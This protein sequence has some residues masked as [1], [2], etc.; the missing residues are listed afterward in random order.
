[1]NLPLPRPR[2]FRRDTIAMGFVCLASPVL[3]AQITPPDLPA[4]VAPEGNLPSRA[5][6]IEGTNAG[7]LSSPVGN[8]KVATYFLP[9]LLESIKNRKIYAPANFDMVRWRDV[10]GFTA[11]KVKFESDIEKIGFFYGPSRVFGAP[12]F[13]SQPQ[14]QFSTF[15]RQSANSTVPSLT[16]HLELSLRRHPVSAHTFIAIFGPPTIISRNPFGSNPAHPIPTLPPTDTFGNLG[17]RWRFN[18]PKV[19]VVQFGFVAAANG[20]AE[21]FTLDVERTEPITRNLSR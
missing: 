4:I 20:N 18:E 8:N 2:R 19:G 15:D 9:Y 13:P 11:V 1:M 12:D 3:A 21:Y 17:L 16:Y 10:L 5:P 6:K 14:G 7:T